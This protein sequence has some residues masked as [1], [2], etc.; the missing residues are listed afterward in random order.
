MT[1][2]LVASAASSKKYLLALGKATKTA[3]TAQKLLQLVAHDP[4]E[5]LVVVDSQVELDSATQL[6]TDL[7]ELRPS[8]G[9]VLVRT[10]LDADTY[11]KAMAS[12][13][14][15]VIADGDVGEL[16]AVSEKSLAIS[17]NLAGPSVP[18]NTPNANGQ[19]IMV[20][21]AKGG[22]G[23]TT[24]STNLAQALA[25][26]D[27][28]R[29]CLVDLDLQF[30]DVAI[31]LNLEPERT[32]FDALS[33]GP[34]VVAANLSSL[35]THH[36]KNLEVLLAPRDPM[37]IDSVSPELVQNLLRLLKD[38][39]D[40]VVVDTPPAISEVILQAIDLADEFVLLTTL[41]APSIKN[42]KLAMTALD[43][44]S[45]PREKWHLVAN[46]CSPDGGIS[47][48]DLER[49]LA[50]TASLAVPSSRVVLQSINC[51]KT[52]IQLNPFDPASV[53]LAL[54]ARK[55][56]RPQRDA[57]PDIK[58]GYLRPLLSAKWA[59]R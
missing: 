51:G 17:R 21:S 26:D 11:A 44:L 32:I 59:S 30:G 35:L 13:V 49:A 3:A 46:Q 41:D 58:R 28:K 23:K 53:A 52:A 55:L 40:Y 2:L 19:L 33:L 48:G 20:F 50:M 57:N 14:R 10:R 24:V 9:V 27:S 5:Q 29:V 34:N 12:G 37:H 7:R 38:E 16:H 31:S 6:A 36:S 47:L 8:L 56:Q 54:L 45:I 39:F 18:E 4:L 43:A 1:A 15:F 42:L 25:D 22:C